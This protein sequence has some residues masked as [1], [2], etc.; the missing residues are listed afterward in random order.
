M[1][2]SLTPETV[3]HN[4][5]IDDCFFSC[6]SEIEA[7]GINVVYDVVKMFSRAGFRLRS[8]LAPANRWI[9][10]FVN[11]REQVILFVVN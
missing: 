6:E 5:Y 4:F 1:H 11:Q 7:I 2:Q 8:G 3:K 9:R 10:Q